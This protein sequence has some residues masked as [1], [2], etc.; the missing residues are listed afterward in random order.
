L[1]RRAAIVEGQRRGDR[2]REDAPLR[3][4]LLELRLAIRLLAEMH[5]GHA[6]D[7]QQQRADGGD[8]HHGAAK[9]AERRLYGYGAGR[10]FGRGRHGLGLTREATFNSLELISRWL[11]A[12][13]RRSISKRTRL[14]TLTKLTMPCAPPSRA[15]SVT[16]S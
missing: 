14:S 13:L 5:H 7:H 8:E 15:A 10:L 11:T 6:G 2:R 3:V 16:V 9:V 12:A 4:D 1:L